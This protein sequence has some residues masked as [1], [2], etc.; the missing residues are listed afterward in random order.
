[1]VCLE[2]LSATYEDVTRFM[3]ASALLSF[4]FFVKIA[5]VFAAGD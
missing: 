3:A 4:L 5:D 2:S 1:M